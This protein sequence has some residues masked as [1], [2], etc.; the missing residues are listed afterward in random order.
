MKVSRTPLRPLVKLISLLTIAVSLLLSP[1]PAAAAPENL[2]KQFQENSD[3]WD[4][5]L[6][7]SGYADATAAAPQFDK[8]EL[9]PQLTGKEAFPKT[10]WPA[11]ARVVSWEHPGKNGDK[12]GLNP[13][14]LTSWLVDGKPAEDAVEHIEEL[15]GPDVDVVFP[16]DSKSYRVDIRESSHGVK[17]LRNQQYRHITVGENALFK[18]GGDGVGRKVYGN[19]WVKRGG[20]LYGQ[21]SMS[22]EGAQDVFVRNDNG[23]KTGGGQLS[24]YFR[25]N[26]SDAS[27]E[28]FGDVQVLDELFVTSGTVIVGVNSRLR[29]GRNADPVIEKGGTL[30]ILDGGIY[31]KWQNDFASR[32]L[33][34]FGTV[35]GGLP[36]RPLTRSA[37]LTL[38]F[39]NHTNQ[40]YEG[41]GGPMEK[42]QPEWMPRVPSLVLSGGA[43]LKT[44]STDPTHARLIV[45]SAD[46]IH[47]R[48]RPTKDSD[49]EQK[50]LEKYPDRAKFYAWYDDLPRGIT[51]A[52][53][54]DVTVENVTFDHLAEG[55]L[56]LSNPDLMQSWQGVTYGPGNYAQGDAL[57][58]QVE[59]FHKHNRY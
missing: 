39:K 21:G 54:G 48:Y 44:I 7:A 18:G 9:W 40:K 36:E 3:Y 24:Q 22:F 25:F 55:G 19:I 43:T 14:D 57:I 8:K 46:E 15:F 34:I 35:L 10:E 12:K 51:I 20:R 50:L 38:S 4:K 58:K 26:K 5:P 37:F 1:L 30:A 45:T 47:G 11:P 6:K 32:D 52:V 53:K 27:V 13:F 2:E 17:G 41:P 56:V 33:E 49:L 28:F 42:G 29:G 59:K 23:W 16:A 31:G